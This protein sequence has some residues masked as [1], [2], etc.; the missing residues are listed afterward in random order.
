VGCWAGAHRAGRLS[1]RRGGVREPRPRALRDGPGRAGGRLPPPDRPLRSLARRLARW[2]V[3]ARWYVIALLPT[4]SIAVVALVVARFTSGALPFIVETDDKVGTILFGVTIAVVI[5]SLEE[6]GWTGFAVP[7]L[8]E[9]RGA[10]GSSLLVGLVWGTWHFPLFWEPDSFTGPLPLTVLLV[11]LYSWLPAFRLLMVWVH[12]RT[13]SLPL[14]MFMH[15]CLVANQLIVLPRSD[16]DSLVGLLALP[17]TLWALVAAVAVTRRVRAGRS[18][19]PRGI[20]SP[21]RCDAP[22]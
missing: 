5:G 13:G 17:A 12:D 22:T 14:A 18:S 3:G 20:G 15:A 11:R 21:H 9:R 1:A 16:A 19:H 2:R 10:L 6:I 8:R 7:R 4:V